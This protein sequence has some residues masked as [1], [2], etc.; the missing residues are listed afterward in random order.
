MITRSGRKARPGK[1]HINV[2]GVGVNCGD[3]CA[4][5]RDPGRLQDAVVGDVTDHGGIWE[6][7]EPGGVAVDDDE[8]FAGT[9]EILR[10]GPPDS[11]PAADDHMAGQPVDGP[12]HPTP[13]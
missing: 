2:V 13:L 5:A 4:G 7:F 9:G 10:A 8:L 11:A 12:V 6:S 1:R 3:Q